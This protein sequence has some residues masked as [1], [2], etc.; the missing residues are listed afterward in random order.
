MATKLTTPETPAATTPIAPLDSK[1]LALTG[2]PSKMY[3]VGLTEDAPF[4]YITVPTVILPGNIRGI[5]P[6][7]PK[8]TANTMVDGKGNLVHQEGQR[9]GA[10]VKL[11][12]VEVE[13]FIKYC[14]THVFRKIGSYSVPRTQDDPRRQEDG[15][16]EDTHWRA[17]IE[18]IDPGPSAIRTLGEETAIQ[19]ERLTK[20]VWI[21][22]ATLD[23]LGKPISMGPQSTIDVMR[24]EGTLK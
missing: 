22:P 16:S 20:Y 6:S 3:H 13:G 12:P 17:D 10:F 23:K 1:S 4:D 24:A 8:R 19:D 14:E 7:V 15:K 5:C 21:V 18:S 11:H 2:G 9:I